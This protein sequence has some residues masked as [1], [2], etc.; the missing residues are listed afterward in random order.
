MEHS[1][2][3]PTSRSRPLRRC[4]ISR[5]VYGRQCAYTRQLLL[6]YLVSY[7]LVAVRLWVG[8]CPR[9]LGQQCT[10]TLP[11]TRQLT[12]GTPTTSFPSVG[13]R[14][15][16]RET[17]RTMP[18]MPQRPSVWDPEIALGRSEEIP[19]PCYRISANVS[20]RTAWPCTKCG[21]SWPASSST[22]TSSFAKIVATGSTSV[23]S[24]FGKR[25]SCVAG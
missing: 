20:E 1:S 13:L 22:S 18:E 6:V 5:P 10:T 3:R 2:A 23:H 19:C 14:R 12:F 15:V 16:Q 24:R 8:G 21:Y 11:A 7:R 25:K 9:G 4:H 17:M